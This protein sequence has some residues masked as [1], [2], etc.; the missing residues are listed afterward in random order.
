LASASPAS[1][2]RASAAQRIDLRQGIKQFSDSAYLFCRQHGK[3]NS[4]LAAVLS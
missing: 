2:L 3:Q 1:L 4:Q